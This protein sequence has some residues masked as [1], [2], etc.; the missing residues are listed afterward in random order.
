MKHSIEAAK[1]LRYGAIFFFGDSK[2][3]K[4][5]GFV[6]ASNYKITDCNGDNYPS[7]MAME[8]KADYLKNVSG[9]FIEAEI[10]NDEINR[11]NAKEFDIQFFNNK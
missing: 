10:Y 1:H 6:E 11:N 3:Y 8:L 5:F 7:F 4:R 2:Y 9:K